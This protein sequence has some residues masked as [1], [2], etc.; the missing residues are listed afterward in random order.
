MFLLLWTGSTGV[1]FF[2]LTC[3]VWILTNSIWW[4]LLCMAARRRINLKLLSYRDPVV[5]AVNHTPG[6]AFFWCWLCSLQHKRAIYDFRFWPATVPTRFDS[7]SYPRWLT[8]KALPFLS[9]LTPF[10][11]GW[12]GI[13]VQHSHLEQA[14]KAAS[15]SSGVTRETW[16]CIWMEHY[17]T[18]YK[19]LFTIHGSNARSAADWDYLP[20]CDSLVSN[21]LP[22][23]VKLTFIYHFPLWALTRNWKPTLL[24]A[25]CRVNECNSTFFDTNGNCLVGHDGSQDSVLSFSSLLL[26]RFLLG[27]VMYCTWV[28]VMFF[29]DTMAFKHSQ[30]QSKFYLFVIGSGGL[31]C[32]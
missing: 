9:A 10:H 23:K 13:K 11:T 3:A 30:L 2:F 29:K 1:F 22:W 32:L 26:Y 24:P 8:G 17:E 25:V 18:H 14:V 27:T 21:N 12:R 7:T 6:Y 15:D 16:Q 4:R 28:G 19:V 31:M 20:V 5:F